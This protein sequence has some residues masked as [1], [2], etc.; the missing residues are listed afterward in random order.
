MNPLSSCFAR[1]DAGVLTIGN[2]L[3]T[4]SW[5][6][7]NDGRLRLLSFQRKGATGEGGGGVDCTGEGVRKN[8]YTGCTECCDLVVAGAIYIRAG[9]SL[10]V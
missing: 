6:S 5:Q 10:C 4:E 8:G 2:A 1:W 3:F 7:E 9:A